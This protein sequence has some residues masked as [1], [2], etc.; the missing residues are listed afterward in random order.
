M[1]LAVLAPLALLRRLDALQ[2]TQEPMAQMAHGPQLSRVRVA[3]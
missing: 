2:P 3:L 1:V